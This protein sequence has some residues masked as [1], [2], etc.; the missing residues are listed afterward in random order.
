MWA[1]LSK[2]WQVNRSIGEW[3][4]VVEAEPNPEDGHVFLSRFEV[5]S[6]F[7]GAGARLMDCGGADAGLGDWGQCSDLQHCACRAAASAGESR[8]RPPALHSAERAGAG[9]G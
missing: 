2:L 5:C 1:S 3:A 7:A 8:R 6:A 4:W 9:R